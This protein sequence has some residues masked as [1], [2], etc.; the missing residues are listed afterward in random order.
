MVQDKY[1]ARAMLVETHTTLLKKHSWTLLEVATDTAVIL[2]Q[3]KRHQTS[4]STNR[5]GNKV[6]NPFHDKSARHVLYRSV[7]VGVT[8]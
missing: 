5:R 8:M 4:L 6:L 1:H 3:P 7:C 2:L